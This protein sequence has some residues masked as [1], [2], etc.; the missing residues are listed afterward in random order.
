MKLLNKDY[1]LSLLPT[2]LR[3]LKGNEEPVFGLMTPQHMI[4]HLAWS[5]KMYYRQGEPTG[6]APGK[7]E[8]YFQEF[9]RKGC[10]FKYFPKD[11]VTKADLRELKYPNMESAIEALEEVYRKF[12]KL[13][14]DQPNYKSYSPTIGEFSVEQLDTFL[15]QH[16]RWHSYQFGLL[17]T[18]S[19]QEV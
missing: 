3:T 18:F 19:S 6:E 12:Y 17:D 7:S 14:E 8:I 2:Q 15:G 16:A 1:I 4:E 5:S 11:G 10:P 13:A 9:V